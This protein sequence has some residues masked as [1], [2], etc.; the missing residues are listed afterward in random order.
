MSG[1]IS[2]R[3]LREVIREKHEQIKLLYQSNNLPWVIGYSGGKDSTTIVQL[4][5]N[6]LKELPKDKLT[7]P[8][9]IISSDTLVENPLIIGYIDRNLKAINNTSK[10][11]GLN[12]E[13]HK[14]IPKNEETFWT[15][16]IGKGYP[17]PRQKFRWCTDRLKINPANAFIIDKVSK[18]GEAIVVLGVR[19]SESASRAAVMDSHKVEGKL[20]RRHSSLINAYVYAPIEDFTTEDVWDYLMA[21]PSPW[22]GNNAE[23]LGLYQSS[24]DTSECPLVVDKTTPSCGNSRFGCWVCTVVKE[25]KSLKG[26]IDSGETWLKPLLVFRN[27]LS[28]IRD[29][30]NYREKKRADGSMYKVQTSEGE[31]IG[32]GPFTL[33]ARRE[34]LRKLLET[35]KEI[36]KRKP[37]SE[38]ISLIQE[39]E[40]KQIRKL[41]L[42]NGDWED[43]LPAIYKSVYD[44]DLN[45][46][47]NERPLLDKTELE[48]LENICI[49]E[50]IDPEIV[51][52]LV[53]IEVENYG[54]K[55]RS[56]IMQEIDKILRQD[57]LHKDIL[58]ETRSDS[59]GLT[60]ITN[61]DIYQISMVYNEAGVDLDEN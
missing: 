11:L 30:E 59:Y 12:I 16:L 4:I 31:K 39:F 8:V 19:R 44:K 51:K 33:D 49:S 46:I 7:K 9:Y 23:L 45:L 41:W 24:S 60:E 47:L 28:D 43:T 34:I 14:V 40:L 32:L 57:W 50:D 21:V 3:G 48:L 10:S 15:L 25:D 29:K 52:K 18:F 17:S 37:D 54:F 13:A 58:N 1:I 56:G 55:I 5:F 6:A 35:E 20:L 27:W 38:K 53:N 61:D 2:T 22:G 26:F 42:D 36:N